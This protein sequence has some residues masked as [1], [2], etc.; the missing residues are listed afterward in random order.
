MSE[1]IIAAEQHPI[2]AGNADEE[3]ESV[4]RVHDGIEIDRLSESV[5]GL[6]SFFLGS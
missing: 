1:R 4:L 5:G 3:F 6:A 2:G